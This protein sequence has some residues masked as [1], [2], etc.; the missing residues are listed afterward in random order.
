MPSDAGFRNLKVWQ[1]AMDA[2]ELTHRHT[3]R[4]PKFETFGLTSQLRRST[5]SIPSNIAEGYKRRRYPAD[6]IRCLTIAN[7]SQGEALTQIELAVRLGYVTRDDARAIWKQ[8]DEV[9]AML[10]GLIEAIERGMKK[11][12]RKPPEEDRS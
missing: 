7:G 6:Y 12:K 4:F 11:N 10:G 1:K 9:G 2:V 5:Q 8:L 3:L